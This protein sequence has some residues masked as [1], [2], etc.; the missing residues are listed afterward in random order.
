MPPRFRY[1]VHF[2]LRVTEKTRCLIHAMSSFFRTPNSD[3]SRGR[4]RTYTAGSCTSREIHTASKQA[5][6]A[7]AGTA[8]EM[9][10]PVM[11]LSLRR[12]SRKFMRCVT[13]KL[14]KYPF[15]P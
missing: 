10:K 1:A 6:A 15:I 9:R 2:F 4:R 5:L 13:K 14:T 7:K 11:M 8:K 12:L 3:S